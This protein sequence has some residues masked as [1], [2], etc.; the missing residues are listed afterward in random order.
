ML[1]IR[2]LCLYCGRVCKS[3]DGLVAH[4]RIRHFRCL[5]A[6]CSRRGQCFRSVKALQAHSLK[7][8]P[9]RPLTHVP[10][11]YMVCSSLSVA[12]LFALA[13]TNDLSG[14][15]LLAQIRA[16]HLQKLR[17]LHPRRTIRLELFPWEKSQNEDGA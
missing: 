2:S 14:N 3:R 17:A 9:D 15:D 6:K 5:D 12:Q 11:A 7:A 10:N 4:Q 13:D 16:F 8:H 1:V